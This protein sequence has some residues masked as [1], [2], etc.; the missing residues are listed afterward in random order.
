MF[1]IVKV[2]GGY[3]AISIRP[4]GQW[5]F[6]K[7]LP[8]RTEVRIVLRVR[9][10]RYLLYSTRELTKQYPTLKRPQLT[11]LCDEIIEILSE[12]ITNEQEYINFERVAGMVEFRHRRRW[13]ANGLIP[14]DSLAEF[15]GHAIDPKAEILV[16]RVQ[17]DLSDIIL[18]DHEPPIDAEVEQENLPY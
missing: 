6:H 17:V 1:L 3:Q 16:T 15:H 12:Q 10:R 2:K 18:M 4:E 13:I 7:V 8:G 9:G 14:M 11:L 5:D